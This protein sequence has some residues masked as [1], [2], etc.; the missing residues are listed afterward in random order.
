MKEMIRNYFKNMIEDGFDIESA[1]ENLE[2]IIEEI[3]QEF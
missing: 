1:K 3:V 2:E